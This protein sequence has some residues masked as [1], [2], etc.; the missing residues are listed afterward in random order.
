MPVIHLVQIEELARSFGLP[1][2]PVEMPE[3]GQGGVFYVLRYNR[4][5]AVAVLVAILVSLYAF[6]HTEVGYRMMQTPAGTKEP[7]TQEP[8]I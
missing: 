3:V 6:I 1:L 5:L 8:M 7:V 4:W 2:R